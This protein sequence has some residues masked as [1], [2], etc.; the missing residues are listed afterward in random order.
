[1]TGKG[2][3]IYPRRARALLGCVDLKRFVLLKSAQA[4]RRSFWIRNCPTVL[5]V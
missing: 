5:I 4:E 3:F 1:M 2:G